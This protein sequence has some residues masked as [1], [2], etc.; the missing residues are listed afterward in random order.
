MRK[1]LAAIDTY[2]AGVSKRQFLKEAMRRDAVIRN[3]EIISEASRRLSDDFKK[4]HAHI[5]WPAIAAA[6]NQYRHEYHKVD[7]ELIWDTATEGLESLRS[8]LSG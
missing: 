6:G 7:F 5:P 3:L 1:A 4:S 8:L 2:M